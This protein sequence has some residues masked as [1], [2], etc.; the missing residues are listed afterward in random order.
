MD[1]LP[2]LFAIAGLLLF[3][4]LVLYKDPDKLDK[5]GHPVKEKRRGR[6]L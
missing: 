5:T 6:I 4:Q 2:I 3:Y 1:F